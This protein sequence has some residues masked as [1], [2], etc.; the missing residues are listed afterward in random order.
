MRT[1][2]DLITFEHP[3]TLAVLDAPRLRLQEPERNLR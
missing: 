1:A 2:R 3:F